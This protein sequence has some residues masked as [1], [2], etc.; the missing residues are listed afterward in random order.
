MMTPSERSLANLHHQIN[1]TIIYPAVGVLVMAIEA[2]NQL[3]DSAR[4]IK[5]FKLTDTYFM[6][7]LAIPDNAQGIETQLV[8]SPS[9]GSSDRNTASWK[10]RLFSH[11]GTQ[12][13]E[14]S[15]GTVQI[16][17]ER[18]PNDLEGH[19]D[20]ERLK[21][22]QN[23]YGAV[24]ESAVFRRTKDEFYDSAFKS[25]YTFG[26]AFRAMENVAYT[27]S[28]SHR[29]KASIDCFEWEAVDGRNHFQEHVVH[30]VTLDGILQVGIAA[31]TRAGEDV[32]P[33]AIPSEIEYIWVSK[34][35]LSHQHADMIRSVGTLITHGNVGYETSTVALDSSLSRVTLEAKGIKLRF[36]TGVAPAQDQAQHPHLCYGIEWKPDI[37]L[38]KRNT[39]PS[40]TNTQTQVARHGGS[41][42][43][44][45]AVLASFLDLL[46]FKKPDM[47]I[48]HV[49]GSEG[50][51]V[52]NKAMLEE[53]FHPQPGIGASFPY[54]E[55]VSSTSASQV[56]NTDTYDLVVGSCV[57]KP[58]DFL[59]NA[60]MMKTRGEQVLIL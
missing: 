12:W 27:D 36:V 29:A 53:L 38:M 23:A 42:S 48:L 24:G 50:G 28:P 5:G 57:S 21:N 22:A 58:Q 35:G 60:N 16:D 43:G 52:E 30:P 46:T 37:D 31:F 41:F 13:Q 32:A 56:I 49:T 15:H 14:H 9:P 40:V 3:A 44:A 1:D 2:A 51:G 6:V 45:Q 26:P 34:D 25:G 8:F 55:L 39:L 47:K 59:H 20:L 18:R 19:E 7:A 17:Y 11:D 10:F 54:L 33:T 4:P